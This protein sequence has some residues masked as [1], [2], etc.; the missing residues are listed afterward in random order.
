V[1]GQPV[2]KLIPPD[3][4]DEEPQILARI[5]RG[6]QI[7][8]YESERQR[9]DGRIINVSLTISPIRDRMG[10][11]M[12]ASKIVRD[13]SERRRWRTAEA[14]E[15]FLSALVESADDAIISK[16]LDGIVTSWNPGAEKVFGYTAKD[17]IGKPISLLVPADRP[18]EEPRIL[19]RIRRGERISHYETK[20]VRKDGNVIDVSI[21]VSPIRDSLGR[22]IGARVVEVLVL[23][24][25]DLVECFLKDFL[26]ASWQGFADRADELPVHMILGLR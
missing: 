6:E 7:E 3:H 13:I 19:E 12:G 1:I 16:N 2:V 9:K 18:D 21:T 25:F 15:S 22:I 4:L 20:R 5:R 10:R 24:V 11:I 8:H 17:M 14:A 26:L 23:F